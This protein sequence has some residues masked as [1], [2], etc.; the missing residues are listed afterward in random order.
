MDLNLGLGKDSFIHIKNWYN[1]LKKYCGDIP[2]V[3]FTNKVDLI[4]K[5]K[6]N[7][8]EIQETVKKYNF[9]KH[10][11]TSAKTG[12]GVTEAFNAIIKKLYFKYKQLSSQK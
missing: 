1:E 5:N 11:T 10:F 12:E 7:K 9:I 2:V 3:L 6:I 4:S 8:T